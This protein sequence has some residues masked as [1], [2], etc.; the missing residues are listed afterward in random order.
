MKQFSGTYAPPLFLCFL[1]KLSAKTEALIV[2]VEAQKQR[3]ISSEELPREKAS[4]GQVNTTV[5]LCHKY[6]YT[7]LH[8]N[9]HT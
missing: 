9:I 7:S 2:V 5:T 4:L 8:I 3:I 1:N 6:I